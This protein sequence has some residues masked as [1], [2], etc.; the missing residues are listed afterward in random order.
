[1]NQLTIIGNLTRDPE[2]RTTPNGVNVCTFSVAVNRKI[3][4]DN[5][6]EADYFEVTAWR[7]RGENC[8]KYLSKGRK[9]CI[10]GAVSVATYTANDGTTRAK[11]KVT[12]DEIEFL[13][14]KDGAKEET[15]VDQGSGY[16]DVSGSI[17]D[18]LPF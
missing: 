7:E 4:R 11:M 16:E 5:E 17:T 8:A 2:L 3:R 13:S 12:A 18:E 9:V 1:M 14:H 10:V 15:K 6:P